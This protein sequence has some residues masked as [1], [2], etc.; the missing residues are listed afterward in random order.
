MGVHLAASTRRAGPLTLLLA[1]GITLYSGRASPAK[2]GGASAKYDHR[3]HHHSDDVPADA[4]LQ[5][6]YGALFG[7]AAEFLAGLLLPKRALCHQK[8]ALAVDD[9]F[10]VGCA[11]VDGTWKFK[12]EK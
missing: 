5:D 7:Y 6:E 2:E 9:L 11:D 8:F 1:L 4:P 12:S 10:F 3:H